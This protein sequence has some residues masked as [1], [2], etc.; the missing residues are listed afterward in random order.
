MARGTSEGGG[1]GWLIGG[2]VLLVLLLLFIFQNTAEVTFKYLAWDFTLPLWLGLL[3][4]AVVTFLVGQLVVM[5]MGHRRR[6]R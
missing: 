6:R 3:I 5:W 2:G 1:K 4:T